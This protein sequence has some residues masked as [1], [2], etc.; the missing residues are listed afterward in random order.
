MFVADAPDAFKVYEQKNAIQHSF[1][2]G[3]YFI[4]RGKFE[5]LSGFEVLPGEIIVS[6]AGT[7]GKTYVIPLAARRGITNQ[8]LMKIALYETAM[9][10]FYLIYF[11]YALKTEASESSKGTALK[12]IPPF[13]LLKQFLTPSRPSPNGSALSRPSISVC[14]Y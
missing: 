13:A 7:I 5:E 1:G 3:H 12:N 10:E 6:C 8:A 4:S 9:Q 2:L 14:R 11:D